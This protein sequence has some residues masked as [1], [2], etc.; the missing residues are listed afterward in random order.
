M[1]TYNELH[2]KLWE[3][4]K[5]FEALK[6]AICDEYK[7]F[8]MYSAGLVSCKNDMLKTEFFEHA[9][10]EHEHALLFSDILKDIGGNFVLNLDDL[11]WRGDCKYYAPYGGMMGLVDDNIKAEKCA[12][13]TYTELLNKFKWSPEHKSIIESIIADEEQHVKDLNK[14]KKKVEKEIEERPE[15]M[16]YK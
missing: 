6:S 15:T 10:E 13:D 11:S 4:Q 9:E 7:A 12:I 14:L 16:P 1:I 3:Y 5:Q 8:L 2:N